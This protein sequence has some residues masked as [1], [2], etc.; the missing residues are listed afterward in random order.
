MSTWSKLA[1]AL[2]L[3][4]AVTFSATKSEA[5]EIP[6]ILALPALTLYSS[7]VFVA[8]DAGF[9]KKEGLNVNIRNLL[10][11]ASTNAVIAGA[12]DFTVGSGPVFL[13]AAAQGQ[14]LLAIAN[15]LDKLMLE[16]VI[17]KDIADAAGFKDG[18]TVAEK[19]K[20]LKGKTIAVQGIASIVHA[21]ERLVVARGGLDVEKDVRVT[22][23]EPTAMLAAMES[24]AIDGYTTSMPFTTQAVLKGSGVVL[25][26]AVTDAPDLIPFAYALLQTRP[27]VCQENREKCVRMTRALAAAATMIQEKPAEVLEMLRKRF[28]QMEAPLLNAAWQT[29]QKAHAKDIRV[30][31]AGLENSEK[32]SIETG[33]LDP[34]DKLKSYDGLFTD[35]YLR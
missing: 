12:A 5:Q 20:A 4:F 17:R 31:L 1:A 24:R 18:M 13:R 16:V 27:Q 25:A 26:S 29:V 10:G 11:V 19:A 28:P 3:S 30:T 9:F 23:M 34:K 14:R 35:E 22:S 6:V 2:G 7:A 15:L 8:E 33:L 32:V 21:W